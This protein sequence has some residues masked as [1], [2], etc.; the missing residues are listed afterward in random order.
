LAVLQI[1]VSAVHSA[2]QQPWVLLVRDQHAVKTPVLLG[3]HGPV[4]VEVISGLQVGDLLVP[5]VNT[6]IVDGSRLRLRNQ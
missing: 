3:L 1:P 5:G 6:D 4:A 2:K